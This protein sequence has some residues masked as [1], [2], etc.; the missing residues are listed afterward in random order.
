MIDATSGALLIF[1]AAVF[2]TGYFAGYYHRG[3]RGR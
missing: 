2:A 3:M 1:F